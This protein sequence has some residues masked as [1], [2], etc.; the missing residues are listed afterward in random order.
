[1]FENMQFT[2]VWRDYQQRVLGE[3]NDHLDDKKLHI[4]AAPGSGKTVLGIE[5]MRRLAHKTIILSPSLTIRNQWAERLHE[6]FFDEDSNINVSH[7]LRHPKSITSTT[8]QSLHSLWTNESEDGD[9]ETDSQFKALIAYYN[10]EDAVTIIVDEAHHLRREWWRALNEFVDSLTNATLVALTATPPYDA[11]FA[12]WTRYNDLCGPVDAEISVPELVRNGDL[13]PH[14]DY[15]HFSIPEQSER[16]LFINRRDSILYLITELIENREVH[17]ILLDHNWIAMTLEHED[18]ILEDPEF[19]SSMLILL[20][21]TDSVIPSAPI[22]MLGVAKREIPAFTLP[23]LEI[24]LNGF[25]FK[26]KDHFDRMKS[27]R[28]SIEQ[29][30]RKAGLIENHRV[31]LH[32]SK[33]LLK[34]TAGSLAKLNSVTDIARAEYDNLGKDLRMVVLTDYVRAADLP[35]KINDIFKPTKLGVLPIFETLRRSDENGPRLGVLTGTLVIVPSEVSKYLEQAALK[36][37]LDIKQIKMSPIKGCP[38][39][40]KLSIEGTGNQKKVALVTQLFNSGSIQILVG[41]QSLLG[42]GWDAPTINSLILASNVGSYMLSNQMRGRAIRI[43]KSRPDKVANI[44]HLAT[45]E[46]QME[47]SSSYL[48]WDGI[49]TIGQGNL[50][51]LSQL[52]SDM[53]LLIKR[54]KVFECIANGPSDTI[55]SG[56]ERLNISE[57][58]WQIHQIIFKNSNMLDLAGKREQVRSKW[59]RSLGDAKQRSHVKKVAETDYAPSKQSYSQTLQYLSISSILAG[60]TSSAG[61]MRQ[62]QSVSNLATLVMI[63]GG[64]AFLFAL[65]K[66]YKVLIL[67]VRNGTLEKSLNQVCLILIDG[68][69]NAGLMQYDRYW[70]ELSIEK[71]IRGKHSITLK[72]ASRAEEKIFFEALEEILSPV[73]NPRYLLIRK[74]WLGKWLRQDYHAVPSAIGMHK[75]QAEYFSNLWNDQIGFVKL[76][77]LRQKSGRKLLLKARSSAMASGFQRHVDQRSEW[78]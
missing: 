5:V 45:V 4:V 30:C 58:D 60:I 9:D 36:I 59:H 19:L 64:M 27:Y 48:L 32:E 50:N 1:M 41:T 77:Y 51:N 55:S 53:R 66:L 74:S 20:S 17:Q 78:R 3:L 56:I 71:S 26:Y 43:D 2:G 8:Y 25:L 22:D 52:G 54:F 42:E 10:A 13:C 72:H 57:R 35:N 37:N 16:E 63:F 7:N 28:K 40:S 69:H 12:E 11:S 67:F 31:K 75:D 62:F 23:W 46:P 6:L 38:H 29:H 70:Y 33:S 44:W 76:I 73:V 34:L 47:I 21:E 24:F 65:P 39:Y 68:L 49:D 15:I 18:S 14:Q 61:L